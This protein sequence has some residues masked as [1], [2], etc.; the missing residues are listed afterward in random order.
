MKSWLKKIMIAF[1][2]TLVLELVLWIFGFFIV[3]P[4]CKLYGVPCDSYSA[5]FFDMFVVFLIF[6]VIVLILVCLIS[7]IIGK[8]KK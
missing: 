8:I 4:K 5:S 7:W 6:F 1:V 2:I 3:Q